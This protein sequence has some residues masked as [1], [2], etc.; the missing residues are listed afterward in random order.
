MNDSFASLCVDVLDVIILLVNEGNAYNHTTSRS[1][2]QINWLFHTRI[3]RLIHEYEKS[4]IFTDLRS[5][6]FLKKLFVNNVH[7]TDTLFDALPYLNTLTIC[8]RNGKKLESKRNSMA[9]FSSLKCLSVGKHCSLK[10]EYF[11][12]LTGLTRLTLLR[13]S[14]KEIVIDQLSLLVNL[15]NL[16]L[17]NCSCVDDRAL[18]CLTQLENLNLNH[19]D[20]ITDASVCLLTNLTSLSL[21]ENNSI[22]GKSLVCMTNLTKLNLHE[23]TSIE[24]EVLYSLTKLQSLDLSYNPRIESKAV[25]KLTNLI[26]LNLAHNYLIDDTAVRCLTNLTELALCSAYGAKKETLLS[27]PLLKTLFVDCVDYFIH[28]LNDES[29]KRFEIRD[30]YFCDT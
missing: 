26:H 7:I 21:A 27:L 5:W 10:N 29:T 19:N 20:T 24:S 14:R 28:E 16:R 15:K 25:Q 18:V 8:N 22:T 3:V 1:L 9:V 13:I 12:G 2:R 17:S 30:N 23:C 6:L 11:G 4:V